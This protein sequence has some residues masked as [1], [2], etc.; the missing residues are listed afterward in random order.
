[1]FPW[2]GSDLRFFGRYCTLTN[3]VWVTWLFLLASTGFSL[4]FLALF[5]HPL[6]AHLKQ[7]MPAERPSLMHQPPK[8][9]GRLSL[10][11]G[12]VAAAPTEQQQHERRSSVVTTAPCRFLQQTIKKNLVYSTVSLTTT[13]IHI[14]V[15]SVIATISAYKDSPESAYLEV[16]P[17]CATALDL[18][19]NTYSMTMITR[20]W[21]PPSWKKFR[22]LYFFHWQ[23]PTARERSITTTKK[24]TL[25]HN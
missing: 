18:L 5:I 16:V 22:R 24:T 4:A 2:L 12:R 1:M 21:V 25:A 10:G 23:G 6:R 15:V 14:S 19:V 13:I 3:P 8:P 20:I 9:K 17:Y 11:W 7:V